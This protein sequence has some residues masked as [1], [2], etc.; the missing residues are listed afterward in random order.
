MIVLV[1]S[2]ALPNMI[3]SMPHWK[4]MVLLLDHLNHCSVVKIR[5]FIIHQLLN[6]VEF[7]S[8][9]PLSLMC[10]FT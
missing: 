7:D 10:A 6:S 5:L 9:L 3:A 1:F 4:R 2:P 8:A